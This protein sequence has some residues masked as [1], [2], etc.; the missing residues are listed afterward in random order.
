MLWELDFTDQKPIP[1]AAP[2]RRAAVRRYPE[3]YEALRS[4][5]ASCGVAPCL[6]LPSPSF[7]SPYVLL[8]WFGRGTWL[9]SLVPLSAVVSSAMCNT[10]ISPSSPVRMLEEMVES[11]SLLQ[12]SWVM[13]DS[14]G[15]CV[16]PLWKVTSL[17][18]PVYFW[19]KSRGELCSAMTALYQLKAESIVQAGSGDALLD[20]F[21]LVNGMTSTVTLYVV[22]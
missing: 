13:P 12:S 15:C 11:W 19:R 16:V 1:F 14:R 21:A 7:T 6:G 3:W 18:I 22:L 5:S 20:T 2:P 8:I 17:V 9:Q 4:V 10:S